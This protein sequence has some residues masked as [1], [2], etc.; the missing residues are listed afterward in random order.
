M[1]TN[2]TRWRPASQMHAV[3][4]IANRVIDAFSRLVMAEA[5][6]TVHCCA[7]A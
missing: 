4:R 5:M 6:A 1:Q 7:P 2:E 3:L